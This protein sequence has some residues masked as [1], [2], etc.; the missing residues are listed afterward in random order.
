MVSEEDYEE[1][2]F[3]EE[4]EEELESEIYGCSEGEEEE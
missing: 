2:E 3:E 1:E 4:F